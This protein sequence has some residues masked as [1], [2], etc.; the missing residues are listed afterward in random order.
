MG[1]E[2]SWAAA[3]GDHEETAE[4]P[5]QV[6]VAATTYYNRDNDVCVERASIQSLTQGRTNED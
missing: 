3:G 6:S 1:E 4:L 5:S 2:S